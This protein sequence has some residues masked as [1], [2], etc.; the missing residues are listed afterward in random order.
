[1]VVVPAEV[2]EV[3]VAGGSAA[4]DWFFVVDLEAG[5]AAAAFD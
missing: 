1:L 4:V 2:A 3:G 5:S